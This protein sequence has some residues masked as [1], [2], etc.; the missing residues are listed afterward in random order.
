MKCPQCNSDAISFM[1]WM[2]KHYA[3]KTECDSC[4]A[5]LKANII[6]YI[7]FI[8]TVLITLSF[9][10]FLDDIFSF[11]N[12]E[13]EYKKLKLL[14]LLPI[15]LIGGY[16]TWLIGDYKLS[17]KQE[18]L[19]K[20]S[21]PSITWKDIEPIVKPYKRTAW[22]P[23]TSEQASSYS[24]SK[25][26]GIPALSEAESWPCC[27]HCNQ[28]M[29]LF[30]QLNSEHLPEEA[31]K[32]FG[33]GLLQVFYCTNDDK[34][35]EMECEAYSPFSKSTLLRVVNFNSVSDK[36]I[37]SSPVNEAFPEKEI[38]SWVAH[39]DYPNCEE[40]EELG[41]TLTDEQTDFLYEQDYPL[42]KDKLLGWPYWVQGVEYP[43]C[44]ECGNKMELIFQIDSEDNIPYMF[45]DV[46]CSHITQCKE[47]KEHLAIAWAC[48]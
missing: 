9:I 4:G 16:I 40:L 46:G 35:C 38:L 27:Q 41:C 44:S 21:E 47:H 24:S 31:N 20:V 1:K 3:F 2:Q 12:I 28:P 32:P 6:V 23:K 33:N 10:P 22:L 5:Q 30:V 45:G 37:S 11:F 25:F 34:E 29:Q 26:S 8:L 7:G 19:K 15:M 39:D 17:T 43:E 18:S 14:A 48:S 36:N 13:L 42:P